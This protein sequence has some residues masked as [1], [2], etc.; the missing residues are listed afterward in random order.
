MT[1]HSRTATPRSTPL[2]MSTRARAATVTAVSASISTPVRSVARTREVIST[3]P[4]TTSRS[5][6]T[7]STRRG[8]ARGS[9]SGHFLTA[10]MPAIRATASA[11][12]LGT[13]PSARTRMIFSEHATKL[14]AVA[15]RRVT[16]LPETSTMR[17]CPLSS[18]WVSR[19][20]VASSMGLLRRTCRDRRV[21]SRVA[22]SQTTTSGCP[23]RKGWVRWAKEYARAPCATFPWTWMP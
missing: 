22:G 3:P 14:R 16:A 9:R 18:R 23:R 15:S 20:V 6:T 19:A 10:L 8:C 1:T 11:S 17:A 13:A 7:P 2:T 12:P 4:S 21:G 5:T